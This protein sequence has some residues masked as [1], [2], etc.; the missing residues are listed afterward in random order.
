MSDLPWNNRTWFDASKS[1][2]PPAPKCTRCGRDKAVCE[3]ETLDDPVTPPPA[4]P[5]APTPPEWGTPADIDAMGGISGC[6]RY[7]YGVES[8]SAD[9][10]TDR[11]KHWRAWKHCRECHECAALLYRGIAARVAGRV[12]GRVTP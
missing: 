8:W 2:P 1:A 3:A 4:P 10:S 7:T 9:E 5:Q 6:R 11:D 12:A